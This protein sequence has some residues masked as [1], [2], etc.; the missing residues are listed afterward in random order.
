MSCAEAL[1]W[2]YGTQLYG[3]KP[4]LA[5]MRR[6]LAA[7]GLEGRGPLYLHVA[8]TNGK[9]S[10]C[11][12]LD[13]ICRAAG[14]RTGLFTSPHLVSYRERIRVDGVYI[15]ENELA[16]GL[17][18]LRG[19]VERWEPHPTFFELT[20]ALALEH[21]HRCG[22]EVVALE[23]GMGGRLDATNVVTPAVSVITRI[24]LDHQAW[25]G[26]TLALVAGEKAGIMKP[27]VPAVS[28]L[29]APEAAAV[30][31]AAGPVEFVEREL[32]G[33]GIGLAGS[34]QRWNAALA[35]AALRAADLP[36][37]D[38]HI[39]AGL[40][41]VEWPGRFQR[42]G[43]MILDGAHN[44]AATRRLVETWREEYGAERPALVLGVLRDKD[45][46]GLCAALAELPCVVFTVPVSS[47]R[48]C[49]PDELAALWAL[50]SRVPC[51]STTTLAE[52]LAR[53]GECAPRVLVTG[54]LF[55]VGEALGGVER[56]AQ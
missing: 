8:G 10:V 19:I 56:S 12:M 26:E 28:A 34:H 6:L 5:P 36:V 20:T 29:Q 9:G 41:A 55:L 11:A 42:V 51:V 30:L 33:V 31:R 47:P 22:A 3:I 27:G 13:A 18:R 46:R 35:V 38:A 2:L 40:G 7:L 24:D 50:E 25:L 16:A 37:T 1:A 4:G 14:L 32:E 21:F 23:T 17:T 48:A 43:R 15:S 45:V 44:P 54:S 53:A 52:A 39:A 49:A